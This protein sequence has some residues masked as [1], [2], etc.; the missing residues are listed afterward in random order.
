M[1]DVRF[2]SCA[3]PPVPDLDTPLL[4]SALTDA[5]I[6]VDVADWRDPSVDW[7]SARVTMLRS[8]WD[9][10]HHLDEFVA[11]AER[12]NAV[13]ELW[14]PFELIRWNTH[15]A[16]LLELHGRGAP[17]LP[18]VVLLAGSAASL[19]GICD[20]AGVERG[21]DQARRSRAAATARASAPSA[22]T[23]RR[24]TSTRCSPRATRSCSRYAPDVARE[25]E[26]SVVL[27]NGTFSHAL[28]KRPA[29]GE[30]RV[31]EHHGGTT[32]LVE[33][34]PAVIE[35]AER[36][37][38]ELPAETLY[39]AHRPRVVERPLARD[40]GRGHRAEPLARPRA[41][42]GDPAPRGRARRTRRAGAGVA[43]LSA[44]DRYA[45]PMLG[46]ADSATGAI[47]GLVVGIGLS[48]YV[49]LLDLRKRDAGIR[50]RAEYRGI[51]GA[52]P[53]AARGPRGAGG[54]RDRAPVLS[55]ARG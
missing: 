42:G 15:K 33:P 30:Y 29:A 3:A 1:I 37:C 49:A 6:T 18:T 52:R 48:I 45:R 44:R 47:V 54:R 41:R 16:Y 12:A 31:Q 53:G 24:P 4:A 19:D 11:W 51:A 10:V 8:P 55:G 25:G 23:G 9:Y 21:G 35:L 28:R 39:A 26:V 22:T 32:E 36:V 20:R 13:T 7:A 27:V 5:G 14:N 34:G 17:V 46:F 38:A 43:G 2:V 40:G 50:T